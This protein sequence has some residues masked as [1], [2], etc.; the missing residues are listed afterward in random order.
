M[1]PSATRESVLEASISSASSW[2]PHPS[3]FNAFAL[4]V[5][6]YFDFPIATTVAEWLLNLYGRTDNDIAQYKPNPFRGWNPTSRSVNSEDGQLSLVDGG[7]DLQNI[8]LQPLIQTVRNVDIIFAIDSSW[9]TKSKWPDG[10]S[11]RAAFDRSQSDISNGSLF[12]A[13]PSEKTFISQGLNRLPT[14]FG[15]DADNLTQSADGSVAPLVFYITN[16]PYS[17]LSNISTF[18][19]QTSEEQRDEIILNGVNTATQ[20]NNTVDKNWTTCVASAILSRSWWRSG[21]EPPKS[22]CE[23]CFDRYCW[24]GKE[25][26][27]DFGPVLLS[28]VHYTQE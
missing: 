3:L 22:A 23:K 20:G 18:Q 17:A 24:D 13:I 1:D 15:C 14:L 28:R 26:G 12:P 10:A 9:D 11:L 6:E 4:D 8:P 16:A 2:A 27:A 19:A 7:E 5:R 25:K 21:E